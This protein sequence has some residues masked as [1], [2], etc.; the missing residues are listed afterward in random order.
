MVDVDT[1]RPDAD[2][3]QKVAR[4]AGKLACRHSLG[5]DFIRL[6]E[7]V[8]TPTTAVALL[9]DCLKALG[10]DDDAG[11]FTVEEVAEHW[12]VS[13][14]TIGD[15][16]RQGRLGSFRLGNR[17]RISAEHIAEYE[18]TQTTTRRHRHL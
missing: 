12:G 10:T 18:R 1:T 11:P 2:H 13:V 9:A 8:N 4:V 14:R 5:G 7:H 16:V 17:I 6:A 3:C 15:L